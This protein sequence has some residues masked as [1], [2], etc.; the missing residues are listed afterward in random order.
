MNY[1]FFKAAKLLPV[2]LLL[3]ISPICTNCGPH[4]TNESYTNLNSLTPTVPIITNEMIEYARKSNYPSAKDLNNPFER[5]TPC[6]F[7]AAALED[8]QKG[9]TT[10]INDPS[11]S[12]NELTAL[13]IACLLLPD[14][15]DIVKAI[16]NALLG[17]GANIEEK[18]M[19][20]GT[21]LNYAAFAGNTLTV[22]LLLQRG[23][24]VDARDRNDWSALHWATWGG[25]TNTVKALL[26]AG[27]DKKLKN[28][29]DQTAY[30]IAISRENNEIAALLDPNKSN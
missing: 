26:Q 5:D 1:K 29:Y 27:A 24:T 3:F 8:I 25:H 15:Q 13:H 9:D 18:A 10:K 21:P 30:D 19:G 23:A 11:G 17:N 22:Q 2:Y 16:V 20:N 6:T 28:N 14:N 7:L 4:S 12:E